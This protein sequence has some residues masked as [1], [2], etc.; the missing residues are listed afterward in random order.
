MGLIEEDS[1]KSTRYLE[2]MTD[3]YRGILAIGTDELITVEKELSLVK[4]YI[5]LLKE[6]F[7]EGLQVYLPEKHISSL[8]PP[9]TIQMLVENAVKHNIVNKLNPLVIT[10]EI[11][12]T[13]LIICN[14]R[15][16]KLS[17]QI[18]TEIGLQNIKKRYLL[19][20][21]KSVDVK[22]SDDH[23]KVILP[24]ITPK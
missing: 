6:R 11:F 15:I 18:S 14:N 12:E 13:E 9:L 16:P 8:I 17:K 20:T 2:H 4:I 1:K 19:I 3:F 23:F 10:I 21:G 5:Y 7:G 22:I 24:V